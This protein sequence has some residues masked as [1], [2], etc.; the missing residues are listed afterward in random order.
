LCLEGQTNIYIVYKKINALFCLKSFFYWQMYSMEKTNPMG[1][2]AFSNNFYIQIVSTI[3][4]PTQNHLF[5]R[6]GKQKMKEKIV[7]II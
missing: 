1:L 6:F 7:E 5:F 4:S 2:K 3:F